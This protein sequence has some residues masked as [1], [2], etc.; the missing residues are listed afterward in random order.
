[1]NGLDAQTEDRDGRPGCVPQEGW[2]VDN[3][4]WE[5]EAPQ[6]RPRGVRGAAPPVSAAEVSGRA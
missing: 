4:F 5:I 1:M 3:T 6:E 2:I